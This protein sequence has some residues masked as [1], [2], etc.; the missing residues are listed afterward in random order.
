MAEFRTILPPQKANISIDYQT[1]ALC[2]GSCFTENIGQLLIDYKFPTSLN[3]FGILYNPIS[4]KNSLERIMDGSLYEL[5]DLFFHQDLWYSFDHHGSFAHPNP[6]TALAKINNELDRATKFLTKTNRLLITVGT[7]S[8]FVYQKTNEVVAN[9]HKLPNTE[10]EKRRLSVSEIVE[11]L[12]PILTQLNIKNRDLEV[13]FTVSPVRHLKD[14]IIENQRSK[15]TL[16]LAVEELVQKLPFV[17]YFPA[18]E[19]VM[20]DLRDYRFYEKDMAHPNDQAIRYIW[21]FFQQTYFSD[22]TIRIFKKVRKIVKASQHRPFHATTSAH[23]QFV[24]KQL[25]NINALEKQYPFLT[26]KKERAIFQAQ[27]SEV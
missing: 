27:L 15:A 3:P 6:S 14:G 22:A 26:L 16:I 18:Y 9:C 2:L 7:A 4:I 1:P 10:F 20:D 5:N 21:D 13:V 11:A 24:Q 19:F 17:H 8:V 25:E 12:F 23:Q